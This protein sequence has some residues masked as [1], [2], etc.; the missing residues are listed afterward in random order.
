MEENTTQVQQPVPKT[1]LVGILIALLGII[2]FISSFFLNK[3]V[4]EQ[5]DAKVTYASTLK[6]SKYDPA[7]KVQTIKVSY[8]YG[9]KK[10]E[11]AINDIANGSYKKHDWI[12]VYVNPSTPTQIFIEKEKNSTWLIGVIFAIIGGAT[13]L[14]FLDPAIAFVKAF[15]FPPKVDEDGNPIEP[16]EDEKKLNFA[17]IAGDAVGSVMN[18]FNNLTGKNK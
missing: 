11:T 3:S 18:V 16:D 6:A 13:F 15:L 7:I 14:G 8:T 4:L 12:K 1:P 5:I 9:N 10:Y 17:E 2:I